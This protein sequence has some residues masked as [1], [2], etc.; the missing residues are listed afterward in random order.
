MRQW[1]E[2][3]RAERYDVAWSLAAKI[4]GERDPATRD[5]PG[6]PYHQRWVWDGRDFEGRHVLVRCYHGL[7]D[8]IQFARYLPLLADCTASVTLEAQPGLVPLL[9][10]VPGIA[11]VPFDPTAPLPA[12]ECDIEI[13]ELDFALR[14]AP[15]ATQPAYI[16]AT[17]AV[18]PRGTIAL[19]N[20]AGG[21]DAGRG[22]PEALFK[23]LCAATPCITMMP[24]PSALPVLNPTGCP[25]DMEVT[26]SLLAGAE[27]VIT[28]DTMIA[29][30]A[31]ALCRP[32]W[33]LL[34]AE[35]DWRWI[36]GRPDTPWYPTMRL[37]AQ[38]EPGDWATVI[39]AVARD[40]TS[41]L[42]KTTER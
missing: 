38:P 16:K 36:P 10:D 41:H 40:L 31:G 13:T 8:T 42:A 30:L 4:L 1:I 15:D 23:S 3:M 27:L 14:I 28:V 6:A 20:G 17:R 12:F 21:W 22:I 26:A 37:Y 5:Q 32:T 11:V 34:Q 33:L 7:G 29:H 19:C 24:G 9:R 25:L 18:L 39:A 2:A 35:P